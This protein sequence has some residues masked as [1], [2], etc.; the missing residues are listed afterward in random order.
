MNGM[1]S[2][3]LVLELGQDVAGPF[4]GKLLAGLG[5]EVI[6]IE[7][8]GGEPARMAGPFKDDDPHP[9]KSGRFLHLNGGKKSITLDLSSP[10]GR[11]LF[12]RLAQQADILVENLGPGAL[13]AWG[14][15]YDVIA[16]ANPR[17]VIVAITY[18]GQDGPYRDYKVSELGAFALSGY[19]YLTGDPEREPVKPSFDLSQYQGGVHAATGA[20][21][22]LMWQD[23]ADTGQLVDVAVVESTCFAHG[24]LSPNLNLGHTYKRAGSRNLNRHPHFQ[25][26]SVTLPCK[27][28]HV[29]VHFAPTDPALL[30][31][32]M[33]DERLSDP[34]LWAEPMGNADRFDE[35]C[36]PWLSRYEKFEVVQRAQELRHPFTPVL[37]VGELFQDEQLLAREM[38]VDLEHPIAGTVAHV[39]PPLRSDETAWRMDRAPLLGEHNAAVYCERLGMTKEDLVILSETGVI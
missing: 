35:L 14:L 13:A 9:E 34:A 25:Y 33:E 22:A 6:K 8:R 3:L 27:Q 28:G 4:C 5:A 1:L 23:A 16:K 31:V 7:P 15:P 2:D 30:G 24:S 39:G 11:K 10:S 18:L 19:M 17:L 26:P 20:M 36:L 38:F 21:A 37:N 12:L 29:H 32:L